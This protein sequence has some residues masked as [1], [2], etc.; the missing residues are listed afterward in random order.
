MVLP[1]TTDDMM[2]GMAR[3]RAL[4]RIKMRTNQT[5]LNTEHSR[6]IVSFN[7]TGCVF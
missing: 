7:G 6:D 2:N 5:Q 3:S 1:G 4:S